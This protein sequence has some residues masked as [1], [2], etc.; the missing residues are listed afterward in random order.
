MRRAAL[1]AATALA[2]LLPASPASAW[3][4][5]PPDTEAPV[6]LLGTA[7]SVRSGHAQFAVEEV[8]AGPDLAPVVELETGVDPLNGRIYLSGGQRYVVTADE[9][10][11][12]S[13]CEAHPVYDGDDLAT[14]PAEVRHPVADG[15]TGPE[16]PPS[17]TETVAWGVGA[18]A[19][20]GALH[21]LAGRRR[22]SGSRETVTP[23][24]T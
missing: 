15:R 19:V 9:S 13:Y 8:W 1:V 23:P 3:I 14:R 11:R 4:C 7:E 2:V 10:F 22:A 5:G 16:R 24:A 21:L 12:T 6:V 18:A 20:A 17:V